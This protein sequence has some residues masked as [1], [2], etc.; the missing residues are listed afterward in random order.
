MLKEWG[1]LKGSALHS[2]ERRVSEWGACI[3]GLITRAEASTSPQWA[4]HALHK[5]LQ[6][7]AGPRGLASPGHL[8]FTFTSADTTAKEGARLFASVPVLKSVCCA[9]ALLP[10]GCARW[11]WPALRAQCRAFAIL[12]SL[13]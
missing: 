3:W 10:A 6:S 9:R 2:H 7:R 4:F 12:V 11:A 1:F 13:Q 5:L 8:P